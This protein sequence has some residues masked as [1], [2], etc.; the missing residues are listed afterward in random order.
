[1]ETFV[2]GNKAHTSALRAQSPLCL[3]RQTDDF[4]EVHIWGAFDQQSI[5]AVRIY[6]LERA[7]APLFQIRNPAR[8]D[9]NGFRAFV[10]R[11]VCGA[12]CPKWVKRRNTR[13]EQ[14][15][16]ALPLKADIRRRAGMSI[17]WLG[18]DYSSGTSC[19]T[20]FLNG[21]HLR[22]E[23]QLYKSYRLVNY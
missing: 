15:F 20:P 23:P 9:A 17:Q 11:C 13:C 8:S 2:L 7:Q 21:E 18:F 4:I 1:M 14:M 6:L 19:K 5:E 16:S 10:F 3:D 22:L 12:A